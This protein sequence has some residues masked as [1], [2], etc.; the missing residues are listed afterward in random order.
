MAKHDPSVPPTFRRR[1]R[2]GLK[3]LR[4]NIFKLVYALPALLMWLS[5]FRF[6]NISI[7]GRIGHLALEVDWF[8]KRR[9]L[10]QYGAI[11]PILM[12]R[13]ERCAN[14][15][16]LEIWAPHFIH[17]TNPVVEFLLRPLM[18][19]DALRIDTASCVM[20]LGEPALYPLIHREWGNRPPVF[21]I[22]DEM[23]QKGEAVLEALGLPVGAWF[24]CVHARD[25]VYS[26]GDES[27]HA[28]RNTSIAL[29]ES[30]VDEIIAHGGW[31]VRM[32][33]KGTPPLRE[34]PSVI[35]YPDTSFKS[36][37]M[38]LFL[39]AR[40]RFFLGN[41]SGICIVS[42]IAGVPSALTNMTPY[43]A[44]L[45]VGTN[46]LSIPKGLRRA[47]GEPLGWSEIFTSEISEYRFLSQFE[48]AGLISVE[49][50]PD[51][52]RALVLEML[53]TLNGDALRSPQD[54]A[55]QQR[56]R[57]MLTEKHYSY[58]STSRLCGAFL[59]EHHGLTPKLNESE[60]GGREAVLWGDRLID[61]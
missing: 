49:N 45:G 21:R 10:G 4:R 8:L 24:V 13:P 54:E 60:W 36:D 43:G 27:V 12:L 9:A 20:G 52:I 37:W 53:D 47:D 5:P 50:T 57:A 42:T 46:D 56:F 44:S 19:F 22:P 41:T 32:G 40:A 34:R 29:C 33:E 39:C 55:L 59:R 2:S 28:F 16:L 35:N 18:Y 7:P 17:V 25:G 48:R 6:V 3:S 58:H 31:C 14:A 15:A 26:P 30:A 23:A 1:M 51:Q 38:D 61:T 11:W